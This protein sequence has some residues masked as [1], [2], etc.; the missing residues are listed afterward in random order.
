M[1]HNKLSFIAVSEGFEDDQMPACRCPSLSLC[2][3][4]RGEAIRQWEGEK[5]RR[6]SRGAVG[7]LM[8]LQKVLPSSLRPFAALSTA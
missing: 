6:G 5:E 4:V 1:N 8:A 7:R 2:V 3:C